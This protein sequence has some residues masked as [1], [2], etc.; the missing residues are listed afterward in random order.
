MAHQPDETTWGRADR[1]RTDLYR[2]GERTA[3]AWVEIE[4][5]LPTATLERAQSGHCARGPL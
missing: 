1:Y 5:R 3:M 4:R 2:H